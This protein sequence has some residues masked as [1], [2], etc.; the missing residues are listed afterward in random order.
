MKFVVIDRQ[1]GQKVGKEYNTYAE[2]RRN[3]DRRDMAYGGYRYYVKEIATT[4]KL[5]FVAPGNI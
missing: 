2:A 3:A 5:Q 1:T 4:P